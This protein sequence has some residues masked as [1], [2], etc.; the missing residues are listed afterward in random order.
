MAAIINEPTPPPSA[1]RGDVPPELDRFVL[2]TLAKRPEDRQQTAQEM[3][4]GVDAIAAR[5]GAIVSAPA[6]SRFVR[7][8]FGARPEPWVAIAGDGLQPDVL[9]VTVEPIP[10][11]LTVA[12][13]NPLDRQLAAVRDLSE[14]TQR[15]DSTPGDR[16][17]LR[18]TVPVPVPDVSQVSAAAAPSAVRRAPRPRWFVPLFV[19]V[20]ATMIAAV[21]ALIVA[22]RSTDVEP[23]ASAAA[24][25]RCRAVAIA[26]IE[27][28]PLPILEPPDATP[29][30]PPTHSPIV[31]ERP[32][33]ARSRA[34]RPTPS[35]SRAARS[36]VASMPGEVHAGRVPR[37][38][39]REGAR[40]SIDPGTEACSRDH[41]LRHARRR[42]RQWRRPDPMRRGSVRAASLV[43]VAGAGDVSTAPPTIPLWIQMIPAPPPPPPP[44]RV[45][46]PPRR[47]RYST[48]RRASRRLVA[49]VA[50]TAGTAG[51]RAPP[52]GSPP[53][54]PATAL[55][56][57]SPPP[58]P[59]AWTAPS[60]VTLGLSKTMMPPEPPPPPEKVMSPPPPPAP[61]IDAPLGVTSTRTVAIR[62]TAPPP[63]PP[64]PAVARRRDVLAAATT[65]QPGRR[66]HRDQ[67]A[68]H[69]AVRSRHPPCDPPR[70]AEAGEAST[71]AAALRSPRVGRSASGRRIGSGRAGPRTSQKRVPPRRACLARRS[72]PT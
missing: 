6:L 31:T 72:R 7:E 63:C 59:S 26:P 44:S 30:E 28:A 21:I 35:S 54:L 70:L 5:T 37:P 43:I 19:L 45:A 49:A 12:V 61:S 1:S 38:R 23:I 67:R 52:A 62:Y 2:R 69:S 13:S 36:R 11:N 50:A 55:L 29:L 15:L 20:P 33:R 56:P 53:L 18:R 4:D 41:R 10:A 39:S 46:V 64:R 68:G 47:R 8:L 16:F 3:L 27:D 14:N 24:A 17:E 22:S 25:R 65:A 51:R 32:H 66:G 40:G 57:P 58:P 34:Y 48:R 60:I 71:G 9:T 42:S